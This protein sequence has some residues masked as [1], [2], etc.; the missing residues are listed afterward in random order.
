MVQNEESRSSPSHVVKIMGAIEI[1]VYRDWSPDSGRKIKLHFMLI[2]ASRWAR[3]F[4]PR[5]FLD[6]VNVTIDASV[7]SDAR[8]E[9]QRQSGNT[10]V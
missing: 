8:K 2:A 3:D 9:I 4:A 5:V 6:G 7:Y 10:H 1:V